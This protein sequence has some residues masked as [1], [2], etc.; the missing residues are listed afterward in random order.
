LE[1]R[2][3]RLGNLIQE[4][5]GSLIV[6]GRVKDPRVNPFLSITRVEVSK[7]LTWADVYVSTFRSGNN[8]ERGVAGL[9]SAAGFMQAQFARE[10]HLRNTPRFRFHVD[11]SLK[12]EFDLIQKIE[13]IKAAE[14]GPATGEGEN[15]MVAD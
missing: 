15:P 12:E 9:Q 2:L 4:K 8:L 6:G 7:D 14:K 11:T 13:E 1:Y 3:E 5:I 10:V